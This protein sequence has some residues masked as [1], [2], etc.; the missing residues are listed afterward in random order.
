M[1]HPQKDLIRFSSNE[2]GRLGGG[3]VIAGIA[4]LSPVG[5]SSNQGLSPVCRSSNNMDFDEESPRRAVQ[6]RTNPLRSEEKSL[7]VSPGAGGG[8]G[9][10]SL[11]GGGGFIGAGCG[12]EG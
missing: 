12:D 10:S 3:G 1:P 6:M 8:G 11:V 5:D 2:G 9:G 7:R 4:G